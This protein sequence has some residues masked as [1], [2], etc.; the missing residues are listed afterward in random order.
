MHPCKV[1]GVSSLGHFELLHRRL[2]LS[3]AGEVQAMPAP[4]LAVVRVEINGLGEMD[5]RLVESVHREERV[6]E[7]AAR[8]DVTLVQLHGS[9]CEPVR[10]LQ[11]D[12]WFAGPMA[13][14]LHEAGEGVVGVCRG[15]C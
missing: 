9:S 1:E 3:D 7:R 13:D 15:A 12:G 10:L 8:I 5:P 6:A 11:H 14:I 4:C 2:M